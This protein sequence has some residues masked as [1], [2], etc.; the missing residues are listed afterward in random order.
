[1]QQGLRSLLSAPSASR[2]A[3]PAAPPRN[4]LT[5]GALAVAAALAGILAGPLAAASAA[6]AQTLPTF[7]QYPLRARILGP[8]G[9]L[10]PDYSAPSERGITYFTG[11]GSQKGAI[12]AAG[13]ADFNCQQTE[14]PDI[15]VLSVPPGG[16]V[17]ISYGPFVATGADGGAANPCI[18]RSLKGLVVRYKGHRAPGQVAL[19][20]TYPTLGAWYD[21]VVPIR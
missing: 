10:F 4:R 2:T 18:G 16:R 8:G 15:K 6:Q 12:F 3:H 14:V 20:V 5:A 1:M 7:E 21:H 19:R 11:T 13:T 9:A 17:S